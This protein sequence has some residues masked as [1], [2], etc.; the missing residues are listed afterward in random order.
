M[1]KNSSYKTDVSNSSK[2]ISTR[3]RCLIYF[4]RGAAF[5][6]RQTRTGSCT[7]GCCYFETI[8]NAL[9]LCKYTNELG[10]VEVFRHVAGLDGVRG[11][12]DDEQKVER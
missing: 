4:H 1:V 2:G 11:A 12:K 8:C 6:L 7:N 10:L 5:R 9:L 3:E